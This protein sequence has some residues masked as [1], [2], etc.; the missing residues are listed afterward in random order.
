MSEVKIASFTFKGEKEG[1]SITCET[2][3]SKVHVHT[4][5]YSY[6][7]KLRDLCNEIMEG[8]DDD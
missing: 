5:G 1:L 8:K 2:A 6:V 7:K 4:E 3:L